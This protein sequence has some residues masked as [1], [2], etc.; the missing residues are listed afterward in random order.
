MLTISIDSYVKVSKI[1]YEIPPFDL[2]LTIS[3][4]REISN[5]P[6]FII[7]TLPEGLTPNCFF[8]FF[9]LEGTRY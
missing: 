6:E 4:K 1:F 7:K 3:K 9:S 2:K 8:F 5:N